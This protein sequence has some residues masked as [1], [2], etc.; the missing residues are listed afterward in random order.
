MFYEQPADGR[1]K[2]MTGKWSASGIWPVA[3]S[4]ARL[5]DQ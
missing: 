2:L 1:K 5:M 4:R 3:E